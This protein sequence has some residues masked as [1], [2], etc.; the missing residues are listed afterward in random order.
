MSTLWIEAIC[1]LAVTKS[2]FGDTGS[3]SPQSCP[4]QCDLMQEIT[5]LRQMVNQESILRMGLETQIQDLRKSVSEVRQDVQQINSSLESSS[6]AHETRLKDEISKVT[7]HLENLERSV[8]DTDT[9]LE[10][11]NNII[12]DGLTEVRQNVQQINSSLESSSSSQ[13]AWLKN[14]ISQVTGKLENLIRSD[15]DMDTR[16]GRI[17]NIINVGLTEVRQDVQQINSS[18]VSSSNIHQAR[19]KTEILKV[20]QKVV[21]L[22]R[23]FQDTGTRLERTANTIIA[24][25]SE[26]K[27]TKKVL[28]TVLRDIQ[29]LNHSSLQLQGFV[30]FQ[31]LIRFYRILY[32]HIICCSQFHIVLDICKYFIVC[33]KLSTLLIYMYVSVSNWFW[34]SNITF[35]H[36]KL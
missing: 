36:L 9:G 34:L 28:T 15:R 17:N 24:M 14:E 18:Q 27:D 35:E 32:K 26:N 12:N 5:L 30:L 13:E 4:Y 7:G 20:E 11:T 8:R 29:T 31:Y 23:L 19:L 2:T 1:F 3:A 16:L 22:E 33:F 25:Q 6:I 10:K 21:K